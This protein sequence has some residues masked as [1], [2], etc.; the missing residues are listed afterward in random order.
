MTQIDI[1]PASGQ[2]NFGTRFED[3]SGRRMFAVP[4]IVL[5]ISALL[6]ATISFAILLGVTPVIP[7]VSTTT[8]LIVVNLIVIACLFALVVYEVARIVRARRNRRAASRLHIRI[9]GLFSL[10][11]AVPAIVVALVAAFTLNQG[12]DRWFEERTRAI[13]DSSSRIAEAYINENARNLQGTTISLAA[14]LDQAESLYNLDRT[15]FQNL[16]TQQVK[17]R[18]LADATLLR[19]NRAAI[20]SADIE[21]DDTLPD[22][23]D[24]AMN[25]ALDG[26]A[27]LIPPTSSGYAG[28]II[29]LQRIPDAYLYSIRTVDQEVLGSLRLMEEN[30]AEY[31]GMEASRTSTQ[32]AFALLYMGITLVVLLSAIWTGIAVADRLVRPIRHLIH[33]AEAVAGGDLNVKLPVRASDGDLGAFSNTFNTMIAQLSG[34]RGA[35]LEANEVIDN[36]RRFIEAVL[37]G[38]TAGIIGV[39]PEAR[40]TILNRSA[41]AMMPGRPGR[42][43]GQ[44]LET[45][46]PEIAQFYGDVVK[47]GKRS[48]NANIKMVR[49]GRERT[50]NVQITMEQSAE[51]AHSH[52]I[53]IDDISDLVEAQRSSVW[54]DVARRIAHEIKNPLT[55]IQLSAERLRRRYGKLVEHDREVFDRCTETII[56]QVGDI[57]RMVDEFSSFAR[58]P[59][60]SPER[61]DLREIAREAVFLVEVSH[62]ET[63][64]RLE[65]GD[66]ALIGLFDSRL[67]GQA[68]GNLVKNASEAVEG[69]APDG[70]RGMVLVRTRAEDAAV[71]IEIIDNGRGFPTQDRHRLLEPY[72]TTR[73][74][75]TGLGLAIV[76]KIV[77]DHDGMIELLDAPP[78]TSFA[79]GAMVRLTMGTHGEAHP[80]LAAAPKTLQDLTHHGQ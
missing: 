69:G 75:G 6:I 38:V 16:M 5:V 10:V 2:P 63:D 34:Q 50:F 19:S 43:V 47:S 13:V 42:A 7:S 25:T 73:D 52:V 23:P 51:A 21:G 48:Q 39:G 72:M 30:A 62:P 53:T 74:K 79:S 78:D 32:I 61:H 64:F 3:L 80:P 28:T 40:I 31:R 60:P 15:G 17:A 14:V 76:R 41:Q 44:P 24:D 46:F 29:K 67:M 66:I 70:G 27:V 65:T 33:A 59:K 18:G 56:R 35:L 49:G 11:A 37:A 9:I 54:S 22:V 26:R 1:S 55:P 12:L 57:G 4:G 36:R 20:V 58:M 8:A 68:V 45:A 77:E 71:I